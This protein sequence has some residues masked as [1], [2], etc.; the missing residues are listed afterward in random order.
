M[1]RDEYECLQA[2]RFGLPILSTF[3]VW[4]R[5]INLGWITSPAYVDSIPTMTELVLT[6]EGETALVGVSW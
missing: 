6:A 4:I 1:T 3:D 5:L 2:L